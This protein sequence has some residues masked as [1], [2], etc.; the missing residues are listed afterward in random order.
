MDTF[1]SPAALRSH[2]QPV[3]AV[4]RRVS[5]SLRAVDKGKTPLRVG[6]T[7]VPHAEILD[8][9][10]DDAV[11]AGIRPSDRDLRDVRRTQRA[12]RRRP[13][14]RELLSVPAVPRRIQP[15]QP[16]RPRPD[17]ARAHRAVRS[18]LHRSAIWTP[19]PT[20]RRS[21]CRRTRSTS[22]V[23]WP[24]S[25]TSASSSARSSAD[26]VVTTADI[27]QPLRPGLE[28][29]E[30]RPARRRPRRLRRRV[31]VRQSGNGFG[32]RHRHG[33]LLR[34]RQSRLRRVP[35]DAVR[36]SATIRPSHALAEAL[37]SESTRDFIHTAYAGRS[38]PRSDSRR[39][40]L[41][42]RK[43]CTTAPRGP[44]IDQRVPGR[45]A[46]GAPDAIQVVLVIDVPPDLA[47]SPPTP[48]DWPTNSE[49][50]SRTCSL[51]STPS[52]RVASPRAASEPPR[53]GLEIDVA[54]R[55]VSID[56]RPIRLAY[57][58]FQL[59][60]Y[61]AA[62]PG[63]TVSRSSCCKRLARP[64]PGRGLSIARWTRTSARLRASWAATLTCS[65]RCAATDTA[66]IRAPGNVRLN[67]G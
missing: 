52:S 23:R 33:A 7:P 51:A 63:R 39:V 59:L 16:G 36:R 67:K 19:S 29:S 5:S 47:A 60:A 34:S 48:R 66:S 55:R 57:R 32:R 8:H 43:F 25:T 56:G 3:V 1:G 58:E 64:A 42:R 53:T 61:L 18:V 14:R 15:P 65:P 17:R 28:G 9:V 24:C 50:R 62:T 20:T 40:A 22:R 26:E 4:R 31:P 46:A 11:A 21:P 35:G 30:Q 44:D 37:H 6:A 41:G 13:A 54:N 12:A 49:S 2:R 27:R 45:A 10:R 38:F